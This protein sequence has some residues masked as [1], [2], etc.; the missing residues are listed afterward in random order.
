MLTNGTYKGSGL[1]LKI[2]TTEYNMDIV[3]ASLVSSDL[4]D[5]TF[6]DFTAKTKQWTLQVTAK[7]DPATGSAWRYV[8]ENAGLTDVDFTLQT[9][10]G[11]VS[12]TKPAFTGTVTI[13]GKPDIAGDVNSTWTADIAFEVD[14][15]PEME[16]V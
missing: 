2:G 6:A 8:W 14:G 3:S 12:D 7:Y 9:H 1:S 10:A 15:E 11:T 4:D 16:T 13:P 5:P